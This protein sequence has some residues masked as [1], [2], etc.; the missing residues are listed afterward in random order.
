MQS[1]F[2]SSSSSLI[3]FLSLSLIIS[4]K[5]VSCISEKKSGDNPGKQIAA[6]LQSK[7]TTLLGIGLL[8]GTNRRRLLVVI[9]EKTES[10]NNSSTAGQLH[11]ALFDLKE[12]DPE[13]PLVVSSSRNAVLQSLPIANLSTSALG[14]LIL[15]D[16]TGRGAFGWAQFKVQEREG[17]GGRGGG[18]G[19]KGTITLD[20]YRHPK[21][22]IVG[23][24]GDDDDA[25]GALEKVQCSYTSDWMRA[26]VHQ[27][28]IFSSNQSGA[29]SYLL[30][31]TSELL[32]G[33]YSV[34]EGDGGAPILR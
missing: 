16:D 12:L 25:I 6:L 32:P 20:W 15:Q 19:E 5:L 31:F 26:F 23:G 14:G 34:T 1:L 11:S 29:F 10:G 2:F 13:G 3:S 8:P 27:L 28:P 22:V 4:L 30:D 7:Q 9:G 18:G 33:A 24:S 21:L 17:G